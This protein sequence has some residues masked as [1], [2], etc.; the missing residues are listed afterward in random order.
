MADRP[1]LQRSRKT[2]RENRVPV[3]MSDAELKA[4][5]D[6]RFANRI[7]TRSDAIRR[8]CSSALGQVVMAQPQRGDA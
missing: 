3:M 1:I 2:I 5:D 8:L 6:W 7:A 4:I